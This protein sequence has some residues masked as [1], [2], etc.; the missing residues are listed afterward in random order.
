MFEND[1]AVKL[2]IECNQKA[3][4]EKNVLRE[5]K[6][7]PKSLRRLPSHETNNI[8]HFHA[9]I[10]AAVYNSER[11]LQECFYSSWCNV[12]S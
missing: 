12:S 3:P 10:S 11:P 2:V 8:V 9:V 7:Y 5:R 4:S 1:G 6:K